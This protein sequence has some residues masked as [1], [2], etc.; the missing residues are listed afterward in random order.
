[1]FRCSLNKRFA[2]K[3]LVCLA[4]LQS[5]ALHFSSR[6]CFSYF[7]LAP[8]L[9]SPLPPLRS[10]SYLFPSRNVNRRQLRPA[11]FPS[12]E[13]LSSS[14]KPFAVRLIPPPRTGPATVLLG[15][16]KATPLPP[17]VLALMLRKAREVSRGEALPPSS[18][19]TPCSTRCPP[20]SPQRRLAAPLPC[21][22]LVVTR[23]ERWL[24]HPR[25]MWLRLSTRCG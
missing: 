21:P 20:C 17:A 9:P 8:P 6:L 10:L 7:G 16:K 3:V 4:C 15:G 23:R 19:P 5:T 14:P 18:W 1:M 22:T 25:A 24:E 13:A 11:G 12:W 2:N